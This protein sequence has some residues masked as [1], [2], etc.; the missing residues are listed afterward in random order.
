MGKRGAR[1]GLMPGTPFPKGM[2]CVWHVYGLRHDVG[3][4]RQTLTEGL[5][6]KKKGGVA[7]AFPVFCADRYSAAIL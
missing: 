2:D 3:A 5:W 7:P 1:A 6:R 4:I